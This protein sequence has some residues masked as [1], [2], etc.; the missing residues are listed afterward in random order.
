[1]NL[2]QMEKNRIFNIAKVFRLPVFSK[3]KDKSH[4]QTGPDA[5]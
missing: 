3:A 4:Y 2:Q 5:L 1:M